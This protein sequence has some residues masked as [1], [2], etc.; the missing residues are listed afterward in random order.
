MYFKLSPVQEN[1]LLLQPETGMGYQVVE[2]NRAGYYAKEKFLVLN[3]E[4]VI[5]MDGRQ[6]EYVNR[7]I[8]EGT[9]SIKASANT[10]TLIDINVFNE[11]QFRNMVT[12]SN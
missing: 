1:Y 5:E 11:R 8:K 7:V 9:H 4:V 3:S 10:V 6:G 2:A 12:E